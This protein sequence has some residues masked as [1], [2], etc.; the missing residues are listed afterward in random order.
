MV[1][2]HKAGPDRARLRPPAGRVVPDRG[3]PPVHRPPRAGRRPRRAVEGRRD[4]AEHVGDRGP[5]R[6]PGRDRAGRRPRPGCRP[7]TRS[8]SAAGR[9]GPRSSAPSRP[10][11][12]SPARRRGAPPRPTRSSGSPSATR[13]GSPAPTTT[14]ATRSRPSSSS[15]A[16]TA[17]PGVV[18]HRRGLPGPVLRRDRRRR[19]PAVLPLLVEAVGEPEPSADGLARAGDGLRPR[20]SPTTAARSAPSTSPSTTSPARSPACRST[21]CSGCSDEIPPTD[22]TLGIDEPAVVAERAARA[23]RFPALKIKVGGRSDLATL[24]AVRG[25]YDGPIRVDANTGWTL[26]GAIALLP[27]AGATS[28]S[29]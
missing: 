22:F 27:D 29:S 17:I 13:S 7:T 2:V 4:R 8:G 19:W 3:A 1:L 6:R 9:C 12:G 18:G 21:G 11:R 5:R 20:R 10:C 15:C 14:P 24:E 28:A 16:T 26:D 23:A 25:V